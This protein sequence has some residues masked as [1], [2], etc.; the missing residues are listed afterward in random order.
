V[1]A[2]LRGEES[3]SCLQA[4]HGR[5]ARCATDIVHRRVGENP[6]TAS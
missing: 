3:I 5:A 4:R 1:I 6:F 2:G